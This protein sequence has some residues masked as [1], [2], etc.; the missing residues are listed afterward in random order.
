V[1][2]R[3]RF[4]GRFFRSRCT[5]ARIRFGLCGRTEKIRGAV[6][7][8]LPLIAAFRRLASPRVGEFFDEDTKKVS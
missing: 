7:T 3:F 1:Y 2:A 6:L 5:L 4:D 8:S